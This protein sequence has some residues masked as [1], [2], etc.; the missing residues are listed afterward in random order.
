MIN[1]GI[2]LV[3]KGKKGECKV[4]VMTKWLVVS[5]VSLSV[6]PHVQQTCLCNLDYK[7]CMTGMPMATMDLGRSA[8]METFAG[9]TKAGTSDMTMLSALPQVR[10]WLLTHV[11]E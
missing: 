10:S 1:Q 6:A 2:S 7:S 4:F 3:L 5:F 8:L 11:R 9:N